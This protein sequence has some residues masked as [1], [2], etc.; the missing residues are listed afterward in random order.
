[1]ISN[2]SESQK[3]VFWKNW[4]LE[5]KG[6]RVDSGMAGWVHSLPKALSIWPLVM[7]CFS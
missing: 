5:N 7:K 4:P 3:E 6:N 2:E 1:M